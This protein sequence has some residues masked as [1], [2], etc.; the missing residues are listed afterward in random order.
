MSAE[1][2]RL[3]LK[4]V[5]GQF[6]A[7]RATK[8]KAQQRIPANLWSAA[9]KLLDYYSASVICRELHLSVQDLYRHRDQHRDQHREKM[10]EPSLF[11]QQR[12]Q[13]NSQFLELTGQAVLSSAANSLTNHNDSLVARR[14]AS[15]DTCQFVLED[16]DGR[17][18][19][20]SLPLGWSRLESLCLNL[21]RTER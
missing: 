20:I 4:Q 10:S 8:T 17:R 16:K 11:E 19:T 9:V 2:L 7:W 13:S 14:A 15:P 6:E 18:L 21:L 3:D 1:K 12:H 5:Q